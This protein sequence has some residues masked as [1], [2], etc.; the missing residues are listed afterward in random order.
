MM[1]VGDIA[2]FYEHWSDAIEKCEKPLTY[3]DLVKIKR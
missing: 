2:Y 1:K 3:K